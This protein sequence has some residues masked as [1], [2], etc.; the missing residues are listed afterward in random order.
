[1]Y[2]T[3]GVE[4]IRQGLKIVKGET[5]DKKITLPTQPVDKSNCEQILKDNGLA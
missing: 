5:V 4:G 2:A 1:V 3:P